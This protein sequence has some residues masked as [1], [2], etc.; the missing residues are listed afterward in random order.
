MRREGFAG[1]ITGAGLFLAIYAGCKKPVLSWTEVALIVGVAL[2][3][4]GLQMIHNQ[5]KDRPV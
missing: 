2:I 3:V 5:L 4:S 1:A